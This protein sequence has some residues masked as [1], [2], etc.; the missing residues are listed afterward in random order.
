[1]DD[2][3][4]HFSKDNLPKVGDVLICIPG[5]TNE[6]DNSLYSISCDDHEYGGM[7]YEEG[8][9]ITV[10]RIFNEEIRP[11]VTPADGG[12]GIYADAL[13]YY[14]NINESEG[15]LDGLEW[16]RDIKP[17]LDKNTRW[18]IINDVDPSSLKVSE[19]IQRYLFKL[20]YKWTSPSKR[21]GGVHDY[22][23]YA[24]NNDPNYSED[25]LWYYSEDDEGEAKNDIAEGEYDEVVKW[26]QLNPNS[27]NESDDFDWIR[28]IKPRFLYGT[29][30]K[31]NELVICLPGFSNKWDQENYDKAQD[32]PSYGGSGYVEGMVFKVDHVTKGDRPVVWGED[33]AMGGVY[34][35][36]LSYY[37]EPLNESEG[38]L[39]GLEWM[40]EI[41]PAI[42]LKPRTIYYFKPSLT[43]EE[44][45]SLRDRVLHQPVIGSWLDR[46]MLNN[47]TLNGV[48]Y[49]V[50]SGDDPLQIEGWCNETELDEVTEMYPK[51]DIIY[52]RESF[53]F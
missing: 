25:G 14:V 32:D 53:I 15:E 12:S 48:K 24:I 44:V 45:V 40:D 34:A 49:F 17:S 19:D 35:D 7:G 2:I 33:L 21:E 47:V 39:D 43:H 46:L 23:I 30:P 38:E 50:T 10:R 3:T 18:V 9:V 36:T 22:Q 26:S 41:E 13:Q 20:G 31:V 37:T 6:W 8:R 28:D 5:F 4:P 52:G 42:L 27:I 16:I 1:M 29:T 51:Y 11:I